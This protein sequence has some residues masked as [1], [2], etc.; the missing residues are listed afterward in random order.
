MFVCTVSDL[1]ACLTLS[2]L[3]P[4]LKR[5]VRAHLVVELAAYGLHN[6][7]T[8]VTMSFLNT[9]IRVFCVRCFVVVAS[10]EA[11]ALC[12]AAFK[13]AKKAVPLQFVRLHPV[14]S[15]YVPLLAFYFVA[16]CPVAFSRVFGCFCSGCF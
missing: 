15:H 1:D 11:F 8:Y 4:D 14:L 16:L 10:C 7:H 12:L 6:V 5:Y 13:S 2:S 9:C 3:H